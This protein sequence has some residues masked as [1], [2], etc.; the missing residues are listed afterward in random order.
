M[1]VVKRDNRTEAVSFDKVTNRI[2]KLCYGLDTNTINPTAIAQKI[3]ARI[4]DGVKTSE[5][6]DLTGQLCSSL[7]TDHP[8]YGVLASRIVISNHQKNTQDTLQ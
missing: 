1:N 5:L 6:D 8:D 3:C 2:N 4:Y 7:A